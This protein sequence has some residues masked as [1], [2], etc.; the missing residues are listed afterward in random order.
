MKILSLVLLSG[1]ALPAFANGTWHGAYIGKGTVVNSCAK[2]LK[3]KD[4]AKLSDT[5]NFVS[6]IDWGAFD[7]GTFFYYGLRFADGSVRVVSNDLVL[8]R[9]VKVVGGSAELISGSHVSYE[10]CPNRDVCEGQC[11]VIEGNEDSA[12]TSPK[13]A[14]DVSLSAVGDSEGGKTYPTKTEITLK[15][16]NGE[17]VYLSYTETKRYHENIKLEGKIVLA[18]GCEL[19]WQDELRYYRDKPEEVQETLHCLG[20]RC[21]W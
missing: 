15:F 9:D 18:D 10:D 16:V 14:P 19:T 20:G 4:S 13:T 12:A 6:T 5:G 11:C 21:R 17:E 8:S 3:S 1:I 7:Y 2:Q